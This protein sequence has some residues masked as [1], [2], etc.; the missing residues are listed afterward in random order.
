[1]KR[2]HDHQ[3]PACCSGCNQVSDSKS[4][5]TDSSSSSEATVKTDPTEPDSPEQPAKH[6]WTGVS[7]PIPSQSL[8]D[9]GGTVKLNYG[10]SKQMTSGVTLN[11]PSS[12]CQYYKKVTKSKMHDEDSTNMQ[13]YQILDY[14]AQP[15][16]AERQESSSVY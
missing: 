16:Y 12:F 7:Y 9:N 4:E 10:S 13:Q 5:Y 11:M 14:G 15:G 1:M 6:S 2:S 8:R 3:D